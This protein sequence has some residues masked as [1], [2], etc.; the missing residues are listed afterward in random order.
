MSLDFLQVPSQ[1]LYPVLF[2]LSI[3]EQIRRISN[4]SHLKFSSV[5]AFLNLLSLKWSDLDYYDQMTRDSSEKHCSS[6]VSLPCPHITYNTHLCLP[7]KLWFPF[8]ALSLGVSLCCL[9][10]SSI[11]PCVSKVPLCG[12]LIPSYY[13]LVS[14]CSVNSHCFYNKIPSLSSAWETSHMRLTVQ[15]CSF[16][17]YTALSGTFYCMYPSWLLPR[18]FLF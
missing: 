7:Q 16:M 18:H 4:S 9:G 14:N 13:F 17:L 1:F 15:F 2:W 12:T 3:L 8:W 11:F 6:S 5:F 10:L